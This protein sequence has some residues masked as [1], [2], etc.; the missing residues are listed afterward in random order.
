[1][2]EG[3]MNEP[4]TLIERYEEVAQLSRDML[5]AAHLEDWEQVARLESRCQL[6]IGYLKRAST[7]V[8]LSEDEQRRRVALLRDI[9]QDDAEVRMRA[10]PWLLE[11][12]QLI[13]VGRRG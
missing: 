13:G 3:P 12:E 9:L 1:M 10:E 8:P 4:R 5:V 2:I 11:L 7:I 6:L